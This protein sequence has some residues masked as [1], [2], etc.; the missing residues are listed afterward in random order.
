MDYKIIIFYSILSLPIIWIVFKLWLY[1]N[2]L[3]WAYT[4]TTNIF[5][6]IYGL[7]LRRD[8]TIDDEQMEILVRSS[9]K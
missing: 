1:T 4:V 9:K 7:S 2:F 8:Q 5:K 6:K 3:V